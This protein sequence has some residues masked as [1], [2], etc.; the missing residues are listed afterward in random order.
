MFYWERWDRD[1]WEHT[2]PSNKNNHQPLFQS[3]PLPDDVPDDLPVEEPPALDIDVEID[4]GEGGDW[5]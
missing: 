5:D 3:G 2:T 4:E 1:V